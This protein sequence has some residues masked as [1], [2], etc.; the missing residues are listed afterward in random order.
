M[1]ACIFIFTAIFTCIHSYIHAPTS[2]GR[3][4][5]C[6]RAHAGTC[7]RRGLPAASLQECAFHTEHWQQTASSPVLPLLRPPYIS[8]MVCVYTAL[9]RQLSRQLVGLWTCKNP[10]A[11]DLMTRIIVWFIG[12]VCLVSDWLIDRMFNSLFHWLTHFLTR[13][14]SLTHSIA[15]SAAWGSSVVR[16]GSNERIM[17]LF[18]WSHITYMPTGARERHWPPERTWY[19]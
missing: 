17:R 6:S 13:T 3:W 4:R 11:A 15:T 2:P 14:H 7:T 19:P 16:Y 1:Y 18:W 8:P 12:L 5:G 10:I 9:L